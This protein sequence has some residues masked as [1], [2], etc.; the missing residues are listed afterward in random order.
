MNMP[1]QIF[2]RNYLVMEGPG[3]T[4][5]NRMVGNLPRPIAIVRGIA[6]DQL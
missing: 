4:E 6:V 2:R 3:K 1:S 5:D